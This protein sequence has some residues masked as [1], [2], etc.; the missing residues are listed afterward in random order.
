MAKQERPVI[1]KK[2]KKVQGHAHHGGAWKIAYADFVTAMMAF[3]LLMWLLAVADKETKRGLADYF[4]NPPIRL[5]LMGGENVGEQT[6]PLPGGG[7]ELQKVEGEAKRGNP[8]QIKKISEQEAEEIAKKMEIEQLEEL[9]EQ[10]TAAID[11]IPSLKPYKGQLLLDLTSEGLRIQI[12]DQENR[13]MFDQGKTNLKP[14]A[15][16]ILSE[17]S[18][19]INDTGKRISISGHTDATAFVGGEGGYSNW[20]LSN[21]RA[22]A[23]RR[24]LISGGLAPDRVMRV[25]GLASTVLLDKENPTNPQNRRIAIVVMNK[26][27][28]EAIEQREGDPDDA[29]PVDAGAENAASQEQAPAEVDEPAAD[30]P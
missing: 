15:A 23:A 24:Q 29:P 4:N 19:L 5:S 21:D 9:K 28:E 14:Y 1:I 6:R 22:N 20:E 18:Q 26:D 27:T 7:T 16:E 17:I 12:V 25:V 10:I 2:I 8:E 3:F 13:P 30:R 11:N